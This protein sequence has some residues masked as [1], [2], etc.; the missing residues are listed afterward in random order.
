M[1]IPPPPP[2][3]PGGPPPPPTF[4]QA[5][6][7]P[8]KLSPGEAGGRGALLSDICRGTKLKKV[9]VVND[10]SEPPCSMFLCPVSVDFCLNTSPLSPSAALCGLSRSILS[11]W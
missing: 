5:N 7:G 4:S 10:R 8:P 1:P 2:P 9:A 11:F 3:P 6:T